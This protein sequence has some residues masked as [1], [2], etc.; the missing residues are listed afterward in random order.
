MAKSIKK[1]GPAIVS[2]S[3][4]YDSIKSMGPM[5]ISAPAVTARKV[6]A[7]GP[8]V[9]NDTTLEVE[10][11]K[12][13]GPFTGSGKLTVAT[14][15]VNGP[16]KLT[17]DIDISDT[18]KINGPLVLN[19]SL[20]GNTEVE[21]KIN[22]PV[23]ADRLQDFKRVKINGPVKTESLT[24]I[25]T[26]KI[27]GK[28]T[29]DEISVSE[30][31]IISLNSGETNIKKITGGRIEIGQDTKEG[32][33]KNFFI[34]MNKPGFAVIDTIVSDGTVE[35]DHVKVNKVTARELFAGEETE[36]GEYIEIQD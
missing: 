30:E 36:I 33:F 9:I 8:A 19:G 22:G 27:N 12:I 24:N 18:C 1:L 23:E 20:S 14:F 3:G 11:L 26:L 6:S 32:F 34:K 31:L 35:L 29:A 4:E 17:G 10:E 2:E 16:I 5:T 15:N 7:M 28:V 21:V 25:D 13:H